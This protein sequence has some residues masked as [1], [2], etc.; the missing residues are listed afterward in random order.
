MLFEPK[1][2]ELYLACCHVLIKQFGSFAEKLTQRVR[3]AAY[4]SF[5]RSGR[6]IEY[7]RSPEIS[8]EDLAREIARRDGIK[9]GRVVLFCAV[10]PCL[11]YQ[12]RGQRETKEIH[13]ALETRKC[14]HLYHYYMHPIFGLMHVRVQTW[15]P[16]TLDVCLNGREWLSRQ[17]DEHGIGYRQQDNCFVWVEDAVKAQALLDAQMR[18]DW[19]K[20][21]DALLEEVHPLHREITAPLAHLNYY[22][23]AT[24]SEFATDVM[25]RDAAALKELYPKFIR[26][27]MQSFSSPDVLR[28]L[29]K[30]VVTKQGAV[31]ANFPGEVTSNC[32]ERPEGV[33]VKHT[34]SGNSVKF[35]DK[36]GSILRVETTILHP[37]HFKVYRPKEAD[38]G[39]EKQ[40]RILRRGVADLW[41]RA[42]VSNAANQRYLAALASVTGSTPLQEEAAAVC[43][44]VK[45]DGRTYRALNPLSLEDGQLLQIISK[46]EFTLNGFRNRDVR[47]ALCGKPASAKDRHRQAAATSRK[48]CILR[49]HHLI[50]KVPKTHR[51]QLT[52]NGRRVITALLAA[53]NADVD[54]L[55]RLAA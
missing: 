38:E 23:S 27:A 50:K 42:E 5:E 12:V 37:E 53:R 3:R 28:F 47:Q 19:P 2:F 21:L 16:F 52:E 9:E 4:E 22:W 43:R 25:F 20:A 36:Q 34:V 32:K 1:N 11:S 48:L 26:H 10:E 13:L 45:K 44:R 30:R 7:L 31:R 8:K 15:F 41:R 18:T 29:G 24:Q 17:M 49:A 6:P 39:G 14:T 46:G 33:R 51:Y 54:Q 40:W 35:Y 55:T